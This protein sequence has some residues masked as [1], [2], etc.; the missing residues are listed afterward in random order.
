MAT[1]TTSTSAKGWSPDV[2]EFAASEV[3]NDAL[4]MQTSTVSGT[5]EGDDP[6]VRVV[7]VDD[8]TADIVPEGDTIDEADPDLAETLISTVKVA[9][10]IRVS[11]EQYRQAGTS[12]LLGES[13]RR[14]VV[15]K[16]NAVYLAQPAPTAPATT[17][18]PGLLNIAGIHDG[19]AIGTDLDALADAAGHIETHGGSASVIVAAPDAWAALRKLKTGTGANTSLLGA[20][21]DD[22]Q[23]RLLGIPVLTSAA[24]PS[25]NLL[26]IDKTAVV[27][28]VGSVLVATSEDVYFA[29]D[30]IGL[31]CTWRIGQN[32]VRPDRVAK[33]TV[34]TDE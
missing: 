28:A 16:A 27:S 17:P 26:L 1:E 33:L 7:Y 13:V 25:G 29:S 8:D 20:G 19:G 2:I 14:A 23:R 12:G 3:V 5:V 24:M 22:A 32:V 18:A 6:V 4:I 15:K 10:L 30:S 9:Q 11:R 34:T 21:T 31:R